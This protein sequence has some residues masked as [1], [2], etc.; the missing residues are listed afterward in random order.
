MIGQV[1]LFYH[2]LEVGTGGLLLQFG[3]RSFQVLSRPSGKDQALELAG[4]PVTDGPAQSL[5][6][7]EHNSGVVLH[8]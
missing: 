7:T 5:S 6:R 4:Q 1:Y 8:S 2:E 3:Q